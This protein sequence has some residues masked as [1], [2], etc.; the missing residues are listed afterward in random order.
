MHRST[1]DGLPYDWGTLGDER[2]GAKS[3]YTKD[4]DTIDYQ[5]DFD[6]LELSQQ[7]LRGE[8][9]LRRIR[10]VY[11]ELA[12]ALAERDEAVAHVRSLRDHDR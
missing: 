3:H 5:I 8:A 7:L 6:V 1:V 10:V 9:A 12:D 11:A 4:F 2:H